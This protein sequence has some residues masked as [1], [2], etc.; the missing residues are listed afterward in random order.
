M[1]KSKTSATIFV[2]NLEI[3]M[4][5]NE[6]IHV[7]IPPR[8]YQVPGTALV[9]GTVIGT[10]RGWRKEGLRFLAENA[11]RAPTTLRGWYFYKKTKNYRMML[12]GLAEGGRQ[13]LK[14]STT[15]IGWVTIEESIRRFGHGLEEAA[16]VGAGV[17]TGALFGLVCE[18]VVGKAEVEGR[19][20]LSLISFLLKKNKDRLGLR[21]TGQSI[22]LG[23]VVGLGMAGM[24]K[25]RESLI[26]SK[27]EP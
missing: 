5:E 6:A 19:I 9:V 13:G 3:F 27:V 14:L 25:G 8:L 11:H 4:E 20:I 22:L 7:N 2:S 17:G 10:V 1:R 12:G 24:R 26:G 16:E 18:F 21:T 23:S 15:A